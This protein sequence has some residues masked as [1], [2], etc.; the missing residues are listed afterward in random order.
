MV[1]S[2]L[3]EFRLMDSI[4]SELI[5]EVIILI[6]RT[7]KT[8]HNKWIRS[9]F[10]DIIF[11]RKFLHNSRFVSH[12]VVVQCPRIFLRQFEF[13]ATH[14]FT[15]TLQGAQIVF[16]VECLANIYHALYNTTILFS[17]IFSF[18]FTKNKFFW[19]KPKRRTIETNF[20]ISMTNFI[21]NILNDSFI[22]NILNDSVREISSETYNLRQTHCSMFLFIVKIVERTWGLYQFSILI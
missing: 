4:E 9:F 15:H 3:S 16:F 22:Y 7:S 12:I 14:F 18:F 17:M 21:H 6:W 2:S 19:Y 8:K 5:R 1:V 13:F 11:N 10:D 20:S